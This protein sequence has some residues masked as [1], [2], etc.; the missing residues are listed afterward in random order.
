MTNDRGATH[1]ARVSVRHVITVPLPLSRTMPLFTP[2]GERLWISGWEPRFPA[3]EDPAGSRRGEVFTTSGDHG[4]T[5]W[6]VADRDDDHARYARITPGATAGFVEVR[7]RE[8]SSSETEV[9]VSYDLT[10]LSDAGRAHLAGFA[11]HFEHEI[12]GWQQLIEA[13]LDEGR[14]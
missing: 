2:E 5:F 4:D 6:V 12:G 8:R 3:G 9:E 7:C 13:A 11:A 1:P 10:A 14:I